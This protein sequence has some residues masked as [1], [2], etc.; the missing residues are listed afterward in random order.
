MHIYCTKIQQDYISDTA[1][2]TMIRLYSVLQG[3]RGEEGVGLGCLMPL[4]TI[5]WQSVLLV[6]ETR[7]P[8][9]NPVYY[10]NEI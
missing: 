7:V 9:E 1:Y 10:K 8:G 6:E 2:V 3:E 5:L 4:S